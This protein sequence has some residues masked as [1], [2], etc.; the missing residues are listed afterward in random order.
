MLMIHEG[1]NHAYIGGGGGGGQ[2]IRGISCIHLK[3]TI[4]TLEKTMV[5]IGAYHE[6]IGG[7]LA[8]WGSSLTKTRLFDINIEISDAM[9]IP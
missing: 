2:Y 4:R 3:G 8:Y 1:G 6:Y 5:H 7:C 9:N